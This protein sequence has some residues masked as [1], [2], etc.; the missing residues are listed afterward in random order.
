VSPFHVSFPR[1]PPP[2]TSLTTVFIRVC[3]FICWFLF[4]TSRELSNAPPPPPLTPRHLVILP[5]L[6]DIVAFTGFPV[7]RRS[8]T[9]CWRPGVLPLLFCSFFFFPPLPPLVARYR[10]FF[11]LTSA[12]P[13]NG[14]VS[15]LKYVPLS[16]S[17]PFPFMFLP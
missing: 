1:A 12:L 10:F 2:L 3:V 6:R 8:L 15:P 11:S 16:V 4:L 5:A 7:P 13:Q 9:F 17:Y 14:R